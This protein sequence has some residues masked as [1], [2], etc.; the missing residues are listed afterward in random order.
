MSWYRSGDKRSESPKTPEPTPAPCG[1]CK[2]LGWV[3]S[4]DGQTSVKCKDCQ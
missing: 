2:D 1:N 4:D 3:L